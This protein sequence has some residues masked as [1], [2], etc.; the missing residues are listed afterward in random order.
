MMKEIATDILP[1][2]AVYSVFII[3]LLCFCIVNMPS[4]K[5]FADSSTITEAIASSLLVAWQMAVM[6]DFDMDNFSTVL[7]KIIFML[8]SAVGTLIFLN[9]LIAVMGDS[10]ER[11]KSDEAAVAMFEQAEV[12]MAIL[13]LPRP[14]LLNF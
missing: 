6:G 4:S 5:A 12:R 11:V 7:A 13:Y 1:Y 9:L 14:P 8:F 10:F 2:F 3:A